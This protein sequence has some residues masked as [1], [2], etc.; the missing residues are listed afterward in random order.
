MKFN[1]QARTKEGEVQVGIVEASSKE[2]ALALL[3]K[4]EF[5]VTFLEEVEAKPFYARRIK[6]FERIPRKDVVIFA[7]QLAIMF[8][9]RVPLTE[10]LETIAKQTS[11]PSFREKILKLSEEV[12][13]GVALSQA[14]AHYPGIF[15]PFF[16]SM[17]R[18]G[19]A[20]GKLSESL[21]YLANHLERELQL[22]SRIIGAIVYPAFI[23]FMFLT[24]GTVM[25]FFV[26]PPLA[27]VLKESTAELPALTKIV[28]GTAEFLKVRGWIVILILVAFFV[29]IW[30]YPKTKE[31]KELFDRISLRIPLIGNLLRKI[32][33]SRFSENL[34][35][36]ISGGLPIAQA[37]EITGEV[38]GNSVYKSIIFI[39]R[40]DVRKGEAISAVL[41]RYPI[42]IPPLVVQMTL[43]GERTGKLDD[44]LMNIVSFYQEEV[45]RA[46]DNMT[47]LLEPILIVF[48]GVIVGGLVLSVFMPLYKFMGTF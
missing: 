19:E 48:L 20:S 9:S 30:R 14:L 21:I 8:S 36:L 33:L 17:A 27:Q 25:I 26:I 42:D 43:V 37:L 6:I 2:A 40:D 45:T 28:L 29:F 11:N 15:S 34:S 4:H 41:A 3:Q 16:V 18:S 1:Y 22:H 24:I 32:Y 38:V 46:L 7:R 13:G 44:S 23:L 47:N 5:Y 31:G 35:T 12:E 10:A 39:A